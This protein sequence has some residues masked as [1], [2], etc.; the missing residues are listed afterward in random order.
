MQLDRLEQ[1]NIKLKVTPKER[2]RIQ[3]EAIDLDMRIAEY[4]KFK[5]LGNVSHQNKL[6]EGKSTNLF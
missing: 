3:K 2:K 6:V 4:I 5:V 1:W